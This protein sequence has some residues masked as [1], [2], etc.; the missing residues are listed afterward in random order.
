MI[1]MMLAGIPLYVCSSGSVPIAY[2]LMRMGVSPG[3]ALVFLVTGPATNAA[4]V[5]TVWNTMGRRSAI[6][7]LA[8]IA[9]CALLAGALLDQFPAVRLG[10]AGEHGS[11]DGIGLLNH[12]SAAALLLVLAPSFFRTRKPDLAAE[13]T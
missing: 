10:V 13:A 1:V 4:A 9:V 3:A 7:Y 2:A 11:H 5:T 8:A 12:L 6:V